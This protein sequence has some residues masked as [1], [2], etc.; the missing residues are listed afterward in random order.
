[1]EINKHLSTLAQ[2][3]ADIR[4]QA[5]LQVLTSEGFAC[6]LQEDHSSLKIPRGTVN[7]LFSST[8]SPEPSPLFCAHYDAVPGSFGA[9]DNAAALC[10]LTTLAGELRSRNIPARFAFFDG[11]ETGNSG[12]K[13]YVKQADRSAVTG[14]INLDVCGYGDTI[15]VCSNG[16]EKK[17]ALE[18]F[19]S[20]ERLNRHR[21]QLLK[22][23]PKSDDY[24]FRGSSI[25]AISVAI[26]PRWDI[27]F[28]KS[29]GS[30]EGS[31]L[32]RPP[33]FDMIMEQMEVTSTM[34][35]SYRDTPE[36]VEPEAMEQVYRY[37]L[38]AVT[39][40]PAPKKLLGLFKL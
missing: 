24:S 12:S 37:L 16:H 21:G 19:C 36:W 13:L 7:Y 20:K 4:R 33:E 3:D 39:A 32:G 26:V 5:V 18:P 40:P 11:E 23:L 1:M 8:E 25:P 28:L 9:N 30:Y 6:T 35:G 17:P 14:V 34:H 22:Y 29:L 10:I 15:A 2:K 27:Q 38:D 31:F